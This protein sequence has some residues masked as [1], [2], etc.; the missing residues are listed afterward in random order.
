MQMYWTCK[1]RSWRSSEQRC[2]C[3]AAV[4]GNDAERERETERRECTETRR[5]LGLCCCAAAPQ[6]GF[7][8]LVKTDF[9]CLR[10]DT[11]LNPSLLLSRSG[12]RQSLLLCVCVCL[13]RFEVYDLILCHAWLMIWLS[14][15]IKTK[16]NLIYSTKNNSR[17]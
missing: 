9:V 12:V 3:A 16:W 5:R 10:D 7:F 1:E 14:F 15:S 17:H 4:G 13:Q 8:L 2:N 6:L 11:I